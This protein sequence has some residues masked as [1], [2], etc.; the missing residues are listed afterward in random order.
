MPGGANDERHPI[1]S[2][3]PTIP[4]HLQ[5]LAVERKRGCMRKEARV[6]R[7]CLV[8]LVSSFRGGR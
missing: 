2:T 8:E 7:E 6:V 3:T 5:S 4:V 1:V